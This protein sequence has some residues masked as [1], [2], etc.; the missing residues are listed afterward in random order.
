MVYDGAA[1][2]EGMS[3]NQAVL[4]GENLLNGLLDVL[5]RFRMGKYACATDVSR[6]FLQIKLPRSQQDWFRIIW[7]EGNDLD[8]G[9]IKIYRFTRLAW[10]V[11]SSLYVALLAFNCLVEENPIDAS[12]V[13]LNAVKENRYMDDVLFASNNLLDT[14]NFAKEGT[15]FRTYYS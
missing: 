10:G 8:G 6:C 11:N 13:T 15:V 14:V 1:T 3:L 2:T 9:K 12:P 7:F 4:A 5:M